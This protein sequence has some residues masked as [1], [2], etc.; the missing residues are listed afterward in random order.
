[1]YVCISF[2]PLGTALS[3]LDDDHGS[4][5]PCSVQKEN[6]TQKN[7]LSSQN[8]VKSSNSFLPNPIQRKFEIITY[9][10]AIIL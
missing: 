8:Q 10:L 9:H 1:M 2:S 3:K 6:V 7:E 4:N 5:S